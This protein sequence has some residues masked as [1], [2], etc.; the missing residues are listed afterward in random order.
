MYT[1]LKLEE[2]WPE[3]KEKLMEV[4]LDLSEEDLNYEPGQAQVLLDHLSKK[5]NRSVEDVKG[6]IESVSFN[7]GKAS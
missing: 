1:D 7:K 6:W 5:M 4:N 3:V 2:P